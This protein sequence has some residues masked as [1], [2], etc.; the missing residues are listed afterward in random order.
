MSSEAITRNDLKAILEGLGLSPSAYIVESGTSGIWT[1]R[2]WSDGTAECW[3]RTSSSSFTWSSYVNGLYY[4]SNNW[5]ISLPFA[6]ADTNYVVTA[7]TYYVGGAVGWV[8]NSNAMDSSTLKLTIVRNGNS[9]DVYVN[10]N[11]KGKWK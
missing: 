2:K 3:G 9:G 4:S 8:A 5:L 1:Y 6:F 7:N 11:V 10:I